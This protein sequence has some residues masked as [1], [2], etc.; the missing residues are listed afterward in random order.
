MKLDTINPQEKRDSLEVL[1]KQQK[2]LTLVGSERKI[3]G[4][5]LF[6]FN[7]ATGEINHAE[8]IQNDTFTIGSAGESKVFVRPNC[9]YIQA[10]N[11]KNAL[12]KA[13][14]QLK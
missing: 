13:M 2:E 1:K 3:K 12:R 7:K 5:N 14:K 9:I 6:E 11:K 8:Y 4:L 10:T